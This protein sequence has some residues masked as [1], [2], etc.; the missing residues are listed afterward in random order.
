MKSQL[1]LQTV[2]LRHMTDLQNDVKIQRDKNSQTVLE[3]NK[4]DK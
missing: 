3:K 1:I 4:K 2:F